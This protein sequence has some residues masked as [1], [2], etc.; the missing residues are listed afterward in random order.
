ME[1][2]LIETKIAKLLTGMYPD[3]EYKA[4]VAAMAIVDFL[5]AENLITILRTPKIEH[6]NSSG[7]AK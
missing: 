1:K 7:A 2:S 5:I 4:V 6:G 3:S